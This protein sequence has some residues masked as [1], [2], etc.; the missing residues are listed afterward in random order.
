MGLGVLEEFM[1]YNKFLQ[2]KLFNLPSVVVVS[3]LMGADG[4]VVI[5][6]LSHCDNPI[7]LINSD[8]KGTTIF[9][10]FLFSDKFILYSFR[11][12][13]RGYLVGRTISFVKRYSYVSAVFC[14]VKPTNRTLALVYITAKK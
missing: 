10:L 14:H 11:F 4:L 3:G 8:T 6:F 9:K 7:K 1:L 2:S 12:I 13:Y 5:P